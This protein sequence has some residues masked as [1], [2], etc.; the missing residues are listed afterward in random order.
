MTNAQKLLGQLTSAGVKLSLTP[1]NKLKIIA[2]KDVLTEAQRASL[3]LY[4][5]EL[6]ELLKAPNQQPVSTPTN[7]NN[8]FNVEETPKTCPVCTCK[9]EIEQSEALHVTFCP[10]GCSFLVCRFTENNEAVEK[11]VAVMRAAMTDNERLDEQE[12]LEERTAVFMY[13]NG[14]NEETAKGAAYNDV[15]PVLLDHH[16]R[17]VRFGFKH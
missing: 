6:V 2:R 1:E 14:W 3:Q 7:E 17:G 9:A 16:E 10:L 11:A 8:G 5:S 13:E 15:L 12:L 4:K